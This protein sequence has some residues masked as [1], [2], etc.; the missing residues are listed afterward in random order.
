VIGLPG[1]HV[2]CCNAFGQVSVNGIP[3]SEPYIVP[4]QLT[5][6]PKEFTFSITV[7]KNSLWVMGDNRGDSRDSRFHLDDPSKGFV[8][9]KDVVGRAF[10]ITWPVSHW[11][12]LDDYP[13]VFDGVGR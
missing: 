1:D 4:E 12:W 9:Y 5:D 8:P 2:S 7:P 3:L 13:H 11:T 6:A 10:V